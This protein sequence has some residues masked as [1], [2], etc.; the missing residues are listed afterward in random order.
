MT[1]VWYNLCQ[2]SLADLF[3][4]STLLSRI[5]PRICWDILRDIVIKSTKNGKTLKLA[6]VLCRGRKSWGV[7]QFHSHSYI[8]L[9]RYKVFRHFWV[10]F[11]KWSPWKQ[12]LIQKFQ[13]P[14]RYVF[15]GSMTDKSFITIKRQ[16]RV[17]KNHK[18]KLLILEFLTTLMV[19]RGFLFWT[20]REKL[21][22]NE[23][24]NILAVIWNEIKDKYYLLF[25]G[26]KP[27]F[28][29]FNILLCT[30]MKPS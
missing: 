16:Q 25:E 13:L 18:S 20:F 10:N 5:N 11:I 3:I 19:Y 28:Q 12:W 17:T 27:K 1:A 30:K 22:S 14:P 8:K 15:A 21:L 23:K 7:K 6:S 4:G 29:K 9:S 24:A 26:I 2:W